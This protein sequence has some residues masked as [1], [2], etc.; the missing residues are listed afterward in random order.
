MNVSLSRIQITDPFWV[1]WQDALIEQ[2]LAHQWTM[3]EETGRLENLRRAA[4]REQG[5][6]QGLYFNDSDVYK[7]L[8]AT[9]YAAHI[10]PTS[11]WRRKMD[12]VFDLIASA[13]E[14]DGYIDTFIQLEHPEK[15]FLSLAA[16]HEMY[17]MGH[18]LEA[19]CAAIELFG[20]QTKAESIAAAMVNLLLETFGEGKRLGFCGHQELEMALCRYS[21]VTG[22]PESRKLAKW[23]TD[24]RGERPSPF[25]AELEDPTAS[26]FSP[27][28]PSLLKRRGE[29]DGAYCQDDKPLRQQDKAVGHAVRAMYQFCGA[30]DAYGNSDTQLISALNTIW[31]NLTERRMYVTG[32]IGSSRHNEGFTD[33]YDLPN[34]HAYAE[35]CAG[36]GLF[37]WAWR[38]ATV[39]DDPT[40]MDVGERALYNAVLS[41]I[42][43]DAKEYH[44]VNPLEGD[45]SH[46]RQPWFECACCPPNIARLILSIGRYVA[47]EKGGEMRILLPIACRIKTGPGE[48]RIEGRYPWQG[49][50]TLSSDHPQSVLIREPDFTKVD[51]RSRWRKLE[52]GPEPV[53]WS[54]AIRPRIVRSNPRVSE[55]LGKVV[56]MR[57]P[58]VYCLNDADS[59]GMMNSLQMTADPTFEFQT[60]PDPRLGMVMEAT[61]KRRLTTE[62]NAAFHD[63]PTEWDTAEI[64]FVPYFAWDATKPLQVWIDEED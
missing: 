46:P 60:R 40:K 58:L 37:M 41:G 1:E 43:F 2:G 14:A 23:M 61:A 42:S 44:Y 52:V 51:G 39:L 13:Q 22:T 64:R 15:R 3:C 53:A 5:G 20:K 28:L 27:W 12:E 50:F 55:N 8:E 19:C 33:D 24:R 34:R 30:L 48:V 17:C 31:T 47:V 56:V 10:R 63:E 25:E 6:F 18:L 9:V 35:T 54:L 29:Y 4:A 57:G 32:G 62:T 16:K 38:M 21:D 45:G 49:E 7:L 36:I 59:I 11:P 26:A